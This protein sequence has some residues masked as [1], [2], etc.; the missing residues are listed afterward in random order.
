MIVNKKNWLIISE[1]NTFR[2]CNRTKKSEYLLHK[3]IFIIIILQ[4]LPEIT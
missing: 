3:G 1:T 4:Y 2:S